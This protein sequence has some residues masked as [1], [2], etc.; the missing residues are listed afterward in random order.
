MI[1]NDTDTLNSIIRDLSE[2]LMIEAGAGTGKTYALVSRVVALIKSGVKMQEIVAITFTEAAAAEL[3]ERI[4]SRLEQLADSDHPD[5]AKDLLAENLDNNERERIIQAIDQLDQAT[6]QTIHGFASQL[7]RERPLDA[8]IP[9]GWAV[10]DEVQSSRLFAEHWDKWLE[11]TLAEDTS[12]EPDVIDALRYLLDSDIGVGRWR[13][14]AAIFGESCA[15][16][17]DESVIEDIDLEELADGTLLK[18]Q[19]L[20]EQCSNR[21]DRLYEQLEGA[22]DTVEAVQTVT[23]SA[24]SAAEALEAGALV[25]HYRRVGKKDNWSAPTTDVRAEF[26]QVG[27]YFMA[28]VKAAPLMPLVRELRRFALECELQRKSEGVATFDDLLAWARDLLRDDSTVREQL[29]GRYTRVLIDE[30]QDTDPLQAEIAFYLAAEPEADFAESPWYRL[31]LTPGRLFVVGDPKQSIYRFRGAD[32]GVLDMVRKGDQLRQLTLVENRRS[33]KEVLDWVN[34][35]FGENGLMAQES[36][37]Q[38]E[39]INLRHHD[40]VQQ[41]E[42]GASVQLFGEKMELPALPLRKLQARHVAGILAAHANEKDFALDVYDKKLKGIRKARLS[43]FC[44]LIQTRTGL[45]SLVQALEDSN[46][47]Y[48]LEGGSILFDT[49]EVRDMLNCLRAIDDPSDEVAVVASLRSPAFACSDTDL[50]TWRSAGG[51]WNYLSPMP[52]ERCLDSPV[53]FG[54]Q[55]IHKYHEMRLTVGVSRL[56]AEFIRDRR[57]DELDLAESRPREAWRRRHFLAEQSRT[58]EYSHAVTPHS[59]PLTLN[60]FLEWAEMQQ[61][62]RARIADAVVADTDD[63]AVRIMTMHASKGLEFP[64]VILLGLAQNPRDENP[65]VLFD[66]ANGTAAVKFSDLRTPDYSG[67]EEA[68]KKHR[69]AESVRLA[70]VAATRARDHL[71]VS[72]F[73]STARSNQQGNSVVASIAG[74]RPALESYCADSTVIADGATVVPTSSVSDVKLPEYDVEQWQAGR[75]RAARKRSLPRAVT[76]T[77]LAKAGAFDAAVLEAEIEDKDAET[78]VYHPSTK[79]RG[80]TAF[81]S[82]LHA[83]LQEIVDLIAAHLP[84]EGDISLESHLDELESDIVRSTEFHAAAHGVSHDRSEIARLTRLALRNPALV[85]ALDSPRLWSEIPVAAEIET[86]DGPVV[87]EGILDL[88]YQDADDDLVVVDYKSDYIPDDATLSAKIERYAWQGAAYA[89]AVAKAS[90]KRVKDVQLLFVRR[91]EAFS[92]EDLD[93]MVARLPEI[94]VKGR[95]QST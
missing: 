12:A 13:D 37:I 68:E 35:V 9:P 94:V 18:L 34:A 74:F 39:Y 30:F 16:L 91:D 6:I 82:A 2:N 36:G 67:L 58:M 45:D 21:S 14:V 93:V 87:I 42:L 88:L 19:E 66:S 23:K 60:K 8:K 22:I 56:I 17:S 75:A 50:Q 10:L 26:R 24:L 20:A 25:D 38:A 27:R 85:S 28:A 69:S 54:L 40:G 7:L 31:P 73:Q 63:D 84:L 62:E 46:I 90:G 59:P 41:Q 11:D 51:T 3:S 89:A 53:R 65:A 83:V 78:D 55:I 33:Q 29:R 64:I 52:E 77:W 32:L 5:N 47:P 80:G 44:I 70:Y 81:G 72:M 86:E 92:I 48:R 76:P 43:E 79:G 49:Q 57:L 61:E 95:D 71:L 1:D 15:R 4:R